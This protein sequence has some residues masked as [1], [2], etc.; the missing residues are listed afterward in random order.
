MKI[1]IGIFSTALFVGGTCLGVALQP[2]LVP[3]AKAET[4][5]DPAQPT[6]A[7]SGYHRKPELSVDRFTSQL[8]LEGE[9]DRELDAIM[10]ESHEEMQALGRAM[11][12]SQDKTRERIV[13]LLTP[14]QKADLDALMAAER[15][16]RSDSEIARTVG[17]YAKILGLSDEQAQTLKGALTDARNRR[18]DL[19]H[20]EDW[21]QARKAIRDEQ[22]KKLE[23]SF[24]PDKYKKYLEVSELDRSD[25]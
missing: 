8:G 1:W 2:K 9:Q 10:S 23:V 25:R 3:A 16:K 5:I 12:A 18:H 22:N 11:K 14:K 24:G 19:K 6:P 13:N 17:T 21:Q 4:R 7:W 20:G 15:Q